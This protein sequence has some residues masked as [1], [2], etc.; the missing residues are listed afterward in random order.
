MARY[1]GLVFPLVVGFDL[2]LT[3][4][5]SRPGIAATYRALSTQ[6]GVYIDADAAVTRLGPP[7]EEELSRW[8]PP[9]EV[10]AAAALFRNLYPVTAITGSPAL[11]GV[12]DAP[13]H[14][15]RRG[16]GVV[17]ITGKYAP[18]AHLHL[19]HIGFRAD[20]VAGWC[21]AETKTA[22][23]LE[24]GVG[25]Y[26]GDH[27]ADMAAARAA[28]TVGGQRVYAVG[29]TTGD[30]SAEDLLAAGAHTVLENLTGLPDWLD[31]N[32]GDPISVG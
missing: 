6:T 9:E 25:V 23:M 24:L 19:D 31:A 21:W 5:D 3:L 10:P 22:A 4:I 17:V 30:H 15:R 32:L 26:V 29:V 11:P 14:V 1:A 2:D 13:A 8:F 16:G 27:P 20:S 18:N 12:G 28:E 7:L